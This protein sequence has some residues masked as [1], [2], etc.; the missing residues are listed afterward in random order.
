VVGDK[1]GFQIKGSV[2]IHKDDG[3]FRQD[4]T[5]MKEDWPSFVPKSAVIVKIT[6]GYV[7][8]PGPD[9]EKKIL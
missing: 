1:G 2:T 7:V 3:I 8:K 9:P 6:D 5:W 4:V